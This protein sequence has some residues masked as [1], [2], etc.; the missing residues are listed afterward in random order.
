MLVELLE[1]NSMYGSLND[2]FN[3]DFTLIRFRVLKHFLTIRGD[4]EKFKGM[5]SE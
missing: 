1:N 5:G 2:V 4:L 3:T